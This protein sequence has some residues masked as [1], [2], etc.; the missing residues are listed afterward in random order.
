MAAPAVSTVIFDMDGVL[1]TY[2]LRVRLDRLAAIAG[3]TREAVHAA[4]W[5]SGFE[6]QAD[7]GGYAD[8]DRY[9]AAFA[10]RLGAALTR[11]EWIAARAAAMT[12]RPGMLSFA[13]SLQPARTIAMLTNNGPATEQA[14]AALF[15]EAAAL[16]G[17]RAFFSWRFGTKKPDPS[18][19]AQ[20]ANRLGVAPAD[21]LFIDDKAHNVTGAMAAG[22][23][24]VHF[25]GE[26]A[27]RAELDRLGIRP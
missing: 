6:D 27:F 17:E 22:M 24:G 2:D 18:I 16:F 7:A 26:T 5:T 8:A 23:A 14:F 9:L 11:E 3:S 4:I 21:C 13:R 10:A 15:P 1:C 12:P 19:F 20:V 25:T